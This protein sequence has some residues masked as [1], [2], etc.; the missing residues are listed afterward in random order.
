MYYFFPAEA[1][2]LGKVGNIKIICFVFW[3]FNTR[4]PKIVLLILFYQIEGKS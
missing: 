2:Y 3:L 4:I 1:P